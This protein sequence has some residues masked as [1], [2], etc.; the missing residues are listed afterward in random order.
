MT[1]RYCNPSEAERLASDLIELSTPQNFALWLA[2]GTVLRGWACSA[3]GDTVDQERN[4]GLAGKRCDVGFAILF[5]VKGGSFVLADRTSEALQTIKEAESLAAT[6]GE[7]W[8]DAELH[9]L[10]PVWYILRMTS[11]IKHGERGRVIKEIEK[12]ATMAVE[13]ASM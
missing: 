1:L 3:S 11:R 6:S 8:G 13:M 5:G 2:R 12:I 4:K 7:H 9:R 10:C